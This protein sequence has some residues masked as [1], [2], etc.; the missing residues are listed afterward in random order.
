MHTACCKLHTA[1][2]AGVHLLRSTPC[3][4]S[5][6]VW[7]WNCSPGRK[8]PF[9]NDEEDVY[10]FDDNDHDDANDIAKD[11]YNVHPGSAL[12]SW[13]FNRKRHERCYGKVNK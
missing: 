1:H 7:G 3:H 2:C 13:Q 4:S 10:G 11:D 5:S 6:P 9:L 12:R 8:K